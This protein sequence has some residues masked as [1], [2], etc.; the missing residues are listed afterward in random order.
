MRRYWV[1]AL[2]VL[3][4]LGGLAPPAFAQAPQPKVTITGLFDFVTT[5]SSNLQ[6]VDTTRR[7]Q[8]WYSRQRGRLD[9]IGELGK[10]KMVWGIELD[11][12][13]G[14]QTV[15]HAASTPTANAG[16]SNT[17]FDLDTDVVPLVETKWLYVQFPLTGPGSILPFIPLETIATGGGQP[18]V[19]HDYKFGILA[20]GDFGGLT[21]V[22]TLA[23]DVK[24]T[25]TFAQ[26]EEKNFAGEKSPLGVALGPAGDPNAANR[27]SYALIESLEFT[28]MK[29]LTVKPT[30][31]YAE[32]QGQNAGTGSLSTMNRGG[33]IQGIRTLH[34]GTV[35]GDVR[36]TSG[37]WSLE[38]TFHYQFGVQSLLPG[39]TTAQKG[40]VDIRA[41]ILDIIGGWRSGPLNLESRFV[42]SSGNKANECVQTVVVAGTT[43]CTGGSNI[44]YYT[45][46]NPGFA[47]FAGWT[48]IWSTGGT[49]YYNCLLCGAGAMSRRVSTGYDKYGLITFVGRATYALTPA[50]SVLGSLSPSWTAQSVDTNGAFAAATGI[51][52]LPNVSKG[53]T[54]PKGDHSY[55][56]TELIVGLSYRFAPGLTFDWRYAH[57]FAGQALNQCQTALAVG[58]CSIAGVAA[59]ASNAPARKADDVDFLTARVR[60]TF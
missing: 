59:P 50:L 38:P 1:L 11:V 22:T 35:G 27:D 13:N 12:V 44:H 17:G 10:A 54:T 15:A 28:P 32:F 48:E 30:V 34:R 16:V 8:E 46:I 42:Y 24:N 19:G 4:L 23:P 39:D 25:F 3:T 2:A 36:W 49:D 33:F 5:W 37:P 18:F 31:S 40:D 20:S 29:G 55:L 45:P 9:F 60:Y 51:T 47:Y 43:A 58:G 26:I 56:G 21:L 6:D 14:N 41:W 53:E 57:L 52:P 7:E